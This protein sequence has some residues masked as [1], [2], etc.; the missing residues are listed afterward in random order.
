MIKT[1]LVTGAT[2]GI[3][4]QQ[5]LAQNKLQNYSLRTP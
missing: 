4:G 2:S 5:I 3:I 1:A